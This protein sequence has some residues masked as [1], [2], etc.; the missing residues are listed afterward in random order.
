M[1]YVSSG[2]THINQVVT[3]FQALCATRVLRLIWL[4]LGEKPAGHEDMISGIAAASKGEG[5]RLI[6]SPL[7]MR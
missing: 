2:S 5:M 6:L 1:S 3:L 4:E 7:Q